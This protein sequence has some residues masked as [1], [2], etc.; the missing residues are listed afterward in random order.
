MTALAWVPTAAPEAPMA[1][2]ATKDSTGGGPAQLRP[3]KNA[4]HGTPVPTAPWTPA[5]SLENGDGLGAT[6]RADGSPHIRACAGWRTE[7]PA[8]IS[9]AITSASTP[10]A[11]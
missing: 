2:S 3:A 5:H 7:T 6:V 11:T 8:A 4:T 1:V 10:R 9:A